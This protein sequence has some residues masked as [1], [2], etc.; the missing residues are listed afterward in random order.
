MIIGINPFLLAFAALPLASAAL[1]R[2]SKRGLVVLLLIAGYSI[3]GW[4]LLFAAQYWNDMQWVALMERTPNPSD[5]LIHQFN[6][7]GASKAFTLLFGLPV[8]AIWCSLCWGLWRGISW[9][10]AKRGV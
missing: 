4:L 10:V 8:S 2:K 1:H 9:L 7:D 5:E 6:S 3:A